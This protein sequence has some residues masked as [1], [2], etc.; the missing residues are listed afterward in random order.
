MGHSDAEV[1]NQDLF[2]FNDTVESP[3]APVVKSGRVT[4][5]DES[6]D[7]SPVSGGR[8]IRLTRLDRVHC[9]LKFKHLGL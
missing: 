6:E 7:C 3:R 8:S 2:V 9:K 5:L 1:E 4:Q